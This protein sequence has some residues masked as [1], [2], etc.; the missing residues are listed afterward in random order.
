MICKLC[1][2]DYTILATHL[3]NTHNITDK[4]YYDYFNARTYCVIC[5]KP[6]AFIS[7]TKG[8]KE[9]C[10]THCARINGSRKTK[11]KYGYIPGTY[12]SKE[13]KQYMLD[14]YGVENA[15]QDKSIKNKTIDTM[16]NKYG[17]SYAF[18]QETAKE[19]AKVNAHSIKS[20]SKTKQTCISKYGVENPAKSNII[21][22]KSKITIF[23]KHN[24]Q[25][26]LD[27]L[28]LSKSELV[29]AS[30]IEQY[31]YNQL[32]DYTVLYNACSDKYPY[33]CDFYVKELDLYIELN[34]TWTH[35]WHYFDKQKDQLKLLQMQSKNNA[36]YN[37]AIYTWT[38][39][40]LQKRNL[41]IK[42]KLNYVVVW[43]KDQL[44]KLLQD[45][46]TVSGFV[47]YNER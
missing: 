29:H 25:F 44:N 10:S 17:T 13:Q 23:D 8:Y 39:I 33:L 30:K 7:L 36:Y 14:T 6:T 19:K 43:N 9:T 24:I 41:A 2:K 1:G 21:K 18:L 46:Q 12:G 11:E 16:N 5:G 3:R 31:F 34:I 40:D 27:R 20:K 26:D 38:V 45:I 4:E 28:K 47:D 35:G 32:Q 42:N 15:Q 37:N 22:E